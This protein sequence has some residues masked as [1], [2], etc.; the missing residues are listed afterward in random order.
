MGS[1]EEECGFDRSVNPERIREI[2]G[3]VGSFYAP[4]SGT[5]PVGKWIG[6][7]P[8]LEDSG[9]VIHRVTETSIWLATGTIGMAF[10]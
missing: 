10:Y 3:E 1:T 9:P 4:V 2:Q 6:F 7:R 8:G 5:Q